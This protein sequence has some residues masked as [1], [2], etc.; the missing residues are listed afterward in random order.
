MDVH[1]CTRAHVY[2]WCAADLYSTVLVGVRIHYANA[3]RV[4][5]RLI[6]PNQITC[7]IFNLTFGHRQYVYV[8]LQC[9]PVI[10]VA[11]V[12]HARLQVAPSQHP[13]LHFALS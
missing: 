2:G 1:T 7:A 6:T 9:A 11:S 10:A 3:T 5:V 13:L 12:V 4:H 8:V